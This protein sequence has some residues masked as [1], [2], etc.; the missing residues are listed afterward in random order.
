[1]ARPPGSMCP[2]HRME[3]RP[4]GET[5]QSTG[6]QAQSQQ[7]QEQA[8]GSSRRF[9]PTNISDMPVEK[10]TRW[11]LFLRHSAHCRMQANC[12]LGVQCAYG[13]QL[14]GHVLTC[15]QQVCNFPRCMVT[16]HLLKHQ[17]ECQDA[18]CPVCTGVQHYDLISSSLRLRSAAAA[19]GAHTLCQPNSNI[20]VKRSA[21]SFPDDRD[22]QKA[23]SEARL[24]APSIPPDTS[25]SHGEASAQKAMS[26]PLFSLPS[27]GAGSSLRPIY[28]SPVATQDVRAGSKPSVDIASYRT[29][30]GRCQGVPG[31]AGGFLV[32]PLHLSSSI[33]AGGRL[34]ALSTHPDAASPESLGTGRKFT[35]PSL[36]PVQLHCTVAPSRQ[37]DEALAV[38]PDPV[39]VEALASASRLITTPA[40]P[41]KASL[42][43]GKQGSDN[44]GGQTAAGPTMAGHQTA[45]NPGVGGGGDSRAQE[46]CGEGACGA[47]GGQ[48]QRPD[49]DQGCHGAAG[50]AQDAAAVQEG[51]GR[52]GGPEATDALGSETDVGHARVTAIAPGPKAPGEGASPGHKGSCA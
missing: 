13:Q 11:L 23:P 38:C 17:R 43:L 42:D 44:S 25:Q 47:D 51:Q 29:D 22:S 10:Q 20:G 39:P 12:S 5:E 21:P 37:P 33:G 30:S 48:V 1:M 50:D 15:S 4:D 2:E 41:S 31:R 3:D 36:P 7:E 49:F 40:T 24:E 52:I 9:L 27:M 19:S 32:A 6:S 46:T 28:S 35:G 34:T 14:W 45:V 18:Q 16:K 8:P 26:A